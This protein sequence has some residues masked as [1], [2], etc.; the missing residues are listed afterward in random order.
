MGS[1]NR[2]TMLQESDRRLPNARGTLIPL[3]NGEEWLFS[4][5]Q[6]SLSADGLTVPKIDLEL[7]SIFD[8]ISTE[9][10]VNLTDIWTV[11]QVLLSSNYNLSDDEVGELFEFKT[12]T[13]TQNFADEVLSHILFLDSKSKGL[14][15]WVRA[16]L[17]ANRI[18]PRLLSL[19]DLPHVLET[20]VATN[21]AIPLSKFAD[22]CRQSKERDFLDSLV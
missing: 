2:Q 19:R 10:R 14:I 18:D 20:L 5:L 15:D 21:R 12:G 7:N 4:A 13:E 8:G 16:S 3:A 11:G 1:S 9:G 17:L 6:I 22:A